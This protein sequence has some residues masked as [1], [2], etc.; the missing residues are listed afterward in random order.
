MRRACQNVCYKG[1]AIWVCILLSLIGVPTAPAW[2]VD[3]AKPTTMPANEA[4]GAPTGTQDTSGKEPAEPADDVAT[5]TSGT[6]SR[7]CKTDD[8]LTYNVTVSF[9]ESACVPEGA[10]LRV[11]LP[12]AGD[13][14]ARDNVESRVKR[15]LALENDDRILATDYLAVSI[16]AG[17]H[18]VNPASAVNVEVQTDAI[19]LSRSAFVEVVVMGT[20]EDDK[21]GTPDKADASVPADNTG[22]PSDDCVIPQ[23]VTD[24][25]EDARISKLSF[26]ARSL[27][28]I[29]LASVAAQQDVWDGEGLSMFVL[30]PR[31]GLA[32]SITDEMAPK[33]EKGM[34]CLAC[35]AI[36]AEP[37][38]AYGTSLWLE[39]LP[40]EVVVQQK[41]ERPGGVLAYLLDEEGGIRGD[42]LC[43]PE[44]LTKP[45][46]FSASSKLLLVR[47]SG[48]RSTTLN[49]AGVTVEGMM[50]E[51][52]KGTAREVTQDYAKPEA[53]MVGLDKESARAVEA[54]TLEVAPLAAYDITLEAG[55]KEY[56]PDE[57]HPLTV[58][59][60][61]SAMR[62]PHGACLA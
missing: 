11:E 13:D 28:T 20:G 14:A 5:Y 57:D 58:T 12:V 53:L 23:N 16:E 60:T 9:D 34:D 27:G 61:N 42:P 44:G 17:G 21:D 45:M 54:G 59:I 8:G 31:Q 15:A 48:Y 22:A 51:G 26:S 39:A 47:D 7:E 40:S 3:P 10:E 41:N 18:V 62:L 55:G 46:E 2:A 35:Y 37:R 6:L 4:K 38:P 30:A 43:R 25:K 1:L 24:N 56:Q 33:L 52:T 29:A 49:L 19:E 50:P 36:Q 32:V